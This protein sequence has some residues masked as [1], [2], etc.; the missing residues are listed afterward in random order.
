LYLAFAYFGFEKIAGPI[1]GY[2]IKALR[3]HNLIVACQRLVPL[4]HD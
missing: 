2:V 1:Y 3:A 4:A